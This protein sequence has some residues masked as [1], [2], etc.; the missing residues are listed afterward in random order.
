MP[1]SP[2]QQSRSPSPAPAPPIAQT[3]LGPRA[4]AL[5]R[6][7][8]ASLQAT[9]T[10][11]AYGHFATCFPTP[12]R[13]VPESLD[14]FWRSFNGRLGEVCRAQFGALLRERDV[15]RGLNALDGLLDAARKRRTEAEERAG[16][17]EREVEVPVA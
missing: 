13:A 9:L 14:G 5:H 15:V 1:T 6:I 7:F 3:P 2:P 12:A 16:G 11:N 8:E 17:E 10:A 4:D